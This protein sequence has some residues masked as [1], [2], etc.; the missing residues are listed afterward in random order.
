MSK[1]WVCDSAPGVS[2]AVGCVDR[3]YRSS[4]DRWRH[5][6]P[7]AGILYEFSRLDFWGQEIQEG[8]R[9]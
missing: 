3:Y 6:I 5:T 2:L 9:G 8:T 7:I 1:A 4:G